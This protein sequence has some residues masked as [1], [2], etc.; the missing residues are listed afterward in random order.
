MIQA[1]TELMTTAAARH[2]CLV[3]T[4]G[5]PDDLQA[6]KALV[7]MGEEEGIEHMA[8]GIACPVA[9]IIKNACVVMDLADL[10]KQVSAMMQSVI[11]LPKAA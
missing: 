11:L 6:A 9:H 3:I 5:E 4:D 1:H 2:V 7:K 8:I 10:P